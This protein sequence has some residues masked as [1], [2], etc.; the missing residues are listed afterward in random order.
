MFL[1]D[2]WLYIVLLVSFVDDNS[3]QNIN[4]DVKVYDFINHET[5]ELNIHP[6][7]R[8]L[9]LNVLVDIRVIYILC[10]PVDDRIL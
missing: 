7:S 4:F 3:L 6:I 8:V 2:Y 1:I 9:L 10:S 5:K